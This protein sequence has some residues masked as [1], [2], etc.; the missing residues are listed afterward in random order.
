VE[1]SIQSLVGRR[2]FAGA[3]SDYPLV[4][5]ASTNGPDSD[6][7]VMIL[8]N[9]STER[10]AATWNKAALNGRDFRILR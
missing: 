7:P 4:K 10:A 1:V 2:V 3:R 5:R 8:S 9:T 6:L